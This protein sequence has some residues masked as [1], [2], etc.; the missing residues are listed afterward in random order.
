MPYHKAFGILDQHAP[1]ATYEFRYGIV[2]S[3]ISEKT[4]PA[5][6][7]DGQFLKELGWGVYEGGWC[8]PIGNL[9]SPLT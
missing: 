8:F 3:N 5:E 7:P 9:S 2:F 4:L 6:S 1:Q